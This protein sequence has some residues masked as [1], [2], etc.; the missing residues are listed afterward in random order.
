MSEGQPPAGVP[1]SPEE[2]LRRLRADARNRDPLGG[3]KRSL[4]RIVKTYYYL[5]PL[6]LILELTIWP[7]WRAGLIFDD[8]VPGI[9]A[10]YLFE[11]AL[12]YGMSRGDAKA[13]ILAFFENL[14]YMIWFFIY[15]FGGISNAAWNP[16]EGSQQM[17]L[18]RLGEFPG[19]Y[20]SLVLAVVGIK[21]VEPRLLRAAKIP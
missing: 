18:E 20:V 14:G 17:I 11:A 19:L 3:L 8:S 9:V 6:W 4:S 5:W 16:T 7:S 13:D 15:Y 21:L 2:I 1:G 10:F 12:A